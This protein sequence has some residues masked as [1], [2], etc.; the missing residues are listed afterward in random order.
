M[1]CILFV[2]VTTYGSG[3]L[4]FLNEQDT[5]GTKAWGNA[6]DNSGYLMLNI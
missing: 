4:F 3:F 6:W 2:L 5:H 1:P